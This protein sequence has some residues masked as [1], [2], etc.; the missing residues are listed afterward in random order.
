VELL[1]LTLMVVFVAYLSWRVR[2]AGWLAVAALAGGI[3]EVAVEL[4]SA[5]PLLAA[6]LLRDDLTPQGARGLIDMYTVA[7]W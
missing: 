5:L 1:G 2:A 6:Y 4:A 3:L 7:F